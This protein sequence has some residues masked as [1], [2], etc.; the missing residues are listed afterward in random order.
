MMSLSTPTVQTTAHHLTV[1]DVVVIYH[2]YPIPHNSD[3]NVFYCGVI[4]NKNELHLYNPSKA[5]CDRCK[6]LKLQTKVIYHR[7]LID[8]SNESDH[9][10]CKV[11]P[12]KNELHLYNPANVNCSQCELLW[13][14][15]SNNISNVDN[16]F[17]K[18]IHKL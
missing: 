2:Y 15:G 1:E 13:S 14:K 11:V 4:P 17:Y 18:F 8:R 5:T 10:D 7:Y 3:V 16:L 12:L 6:A 9:P